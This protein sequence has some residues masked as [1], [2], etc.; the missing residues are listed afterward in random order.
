VDLVEVVIY[1]ETQVAASQDERLL[2]IIDVGRESI[3][4]MVVVDVK[5]DWIK[6]PW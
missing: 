3:I 1:Q 2:A 5:D 6:S 4:S